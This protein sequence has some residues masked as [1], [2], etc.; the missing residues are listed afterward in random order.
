[1]WAN[2]SNDAGTP[3]TGGAPSTTLPMMLRRRATLVGRAALSAAM[4]LPNVE[5]ARYVLSSRHGELNRT[6]SILRCLVLKEPVSPADF[7][8]SVHHGLAGLLS[9]ALQNS[10]GHTAISAGPESFCYGLLEAAVC[11]V[12]SPAEPV[13]LIYYD[14]KPDTLFPSSSG[15][16]GAA[17]PIVAALCLGH[18]ATNDGPVISMKTSELDD[19]Q[20]SESLVRD[21]LAFLLGGDD[22]LKLRGD[23]LSWEWSP[24]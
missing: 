2:T 4:G 3:E 20:T 16:S 6:L 18:A 8:M 23:R 11:I 24:G 1:M 10:K 9:I 17:A 21:F 14:E 22:S 19:G 13:I 5:E 12:E 7:S 15:S